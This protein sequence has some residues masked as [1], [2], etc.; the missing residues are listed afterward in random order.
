MTFV[1]SADADWKADSGWTYR[2]DFRCLWQGAK[3]DH[4]SVYRGG[5]T[6]ARS[7]AWMEYWDPFN[8]HV[9]CGERDAPSYHLAVKYAHFKYTSS[10]WAVCRYVSWYYNSTGEAIVILER[11]RQA[12]KCGSGQYLT[13]GDGAIK[14]NNQWQYG[15]LYSPVHWLG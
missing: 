5:I 7:D 8:G 10:G 14:D 1:P 15:T 9:R 4:T 2:S 11:K 12:V 3:I 6:R 13:R